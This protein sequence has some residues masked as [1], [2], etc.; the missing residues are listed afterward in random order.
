LW[1]WQEVRVANKYGAVKTEL[2]GHVFDSKAEAAHYG[3]LKLLMAGGEV[4]GIEIQP[5]FMFSSGI[6]YR[7]DFRVRFADGREEIQDVKG[8][9]TAVYQL[10]KKLMLHEFGIKVVEI[11]V[12]KKPRRKPG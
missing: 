12:K 9:K 7:A 4:T 10:K 3:K 1:V 8:M 11:G 5:E 2:D 6:K